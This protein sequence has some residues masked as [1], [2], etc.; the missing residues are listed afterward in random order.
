MFVLKIE[1]ERGNR[2]QLTQ[3]PRYTLT[4]VTGLNPPNANINT[5]TNANFDGSVYKS[6]RVNSRNI[7][8]TLAIEGDVETNRILLYRFIKV[9][10]QVTIYVQNNS[11]NVQI[12]GY[13]ESFEIGLFDNKQMAQISI[14]CPKPYFSDITSNSV[15]FLSYKSLFEFPFS[16]AQEGIEFSRLVVGEETSV[17]N[18][19]DAT[20]GM[21]LSFKALGTVVN[22]T[23]YNVETRESLKVNI[24]LNEGDA[25]NINTNQGQKSVTYVSQGLST[26]VINNLDA[27]SSWLQLEPGENILLYTADQYPQF[28]IC[29]LIFNDQY[30]GV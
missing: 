21:T 26:N 29:N 13:V 19:G 25:L 12:T 23:L 30:E 2:I 10:K 24:T 16:I 4:S 3:N 18:L 9:K 28:L 5:A 15:N 11:R 6:S 17:F 14:L 27:S 22:P 8:I 7:V 1:N 20:T